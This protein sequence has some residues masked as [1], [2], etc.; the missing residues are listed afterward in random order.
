MATIERDPG[1]IDFGDSDRGDYDP[2]EVSNVVSNAW[3]PS[4]LSAKPEALPRKTPIGC[5]ALSAAKSLIT[6]REAAKKAQGTAR[7]C[8]G[9]RDTPEA[10]RR[11]IARSAGLPLDV[12]AKLDRDLTETEKAMIRNAAARL[13]ERA[14]ALFA[15]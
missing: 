9:W 11:L 3:H 13:K 12:V 10:F 14:D 7:S 1:D 6:P 2:T 8:R 15:L 4:F 5:A